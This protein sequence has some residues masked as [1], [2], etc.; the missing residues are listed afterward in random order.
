ML[1]V[2]NSIKNAYNQYTTQRKSY[3]Q[4]G[5]N[6]YFIQNMD[7]YADAYDEG[8]VVG[9]AIAKILKFDIETQYVRGL[10]E[11]TLYDGKI[12]IGRASCRE[13]V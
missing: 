13:R 3:I 5:N 11:F 12:E 1:N 8:N 7:L 2:S 9:N 10:D 6:Q 4:V